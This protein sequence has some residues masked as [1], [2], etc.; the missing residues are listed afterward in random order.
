M[1]APDTKTLTSRRKPTKMTTIDEKTLKAK[2]WWYGGK[3]HYVTIENDMMYCGAY[4]SLSKTSLIVLHRFLQKR[5]W[6]KKTKEY[7][8][9][10]TLS[11]SYMEA[12]CFGISAPQ[13]KR[14]IKELVKFGFLVVHHQ[15]GGFG[16]KH[17]F[18]IYK[19]SGQ[20]RLYGTP[21]FKNPV[22][23]PCPSNGGIE[24]HN[25]SEAVKREKARKE[26]WAKTYY[27]DSPLC[28]V[29]E[30]TAPMVKLDHIRGSNLTTISP[31]ENEEG[32]L[33]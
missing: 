26:G 7:L 11:F 18:S 21:Y 20:W 12:K 14:A 15:G 32:V 6:K 30:N 3:G 16:N 8:P 31:Q 19:L 25:E 10:E 28:S 22:K 13:F 33:I 24:H 1:Q 23:E 29:K 27:P 9:N 2:G 5:T 17:D 4:H